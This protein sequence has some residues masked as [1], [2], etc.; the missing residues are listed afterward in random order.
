MADQVQAAD[1]LAAEA[2]QHECWPFNHD[3]T[4]CACP[5]HHTM[6]TFKHQRQLQYSRSNVPAHDNANA[7][8]SGYLPAIHTDDRCWLQCHC[9]RDAVRT[10]KPDGTALA[11]DA[12]VNNIIVRFATK[13]Y[14]CR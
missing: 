4:S 3:C 14:M 1:L 10:A 2:P 11:T 5:L 13:L 6:Q 9:V 7:E 8:C 12:R